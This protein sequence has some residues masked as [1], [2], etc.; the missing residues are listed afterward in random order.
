[1]ISIRLFKKIAIPGICVEWVFLKPE[2]EK[3][4]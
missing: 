2:A 4:W 1:L 3:V